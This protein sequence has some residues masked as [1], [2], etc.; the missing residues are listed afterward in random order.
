[1][2]SA[3]VWNEIF[4]PRL[5]ST[6]NDSQL[7]AV[8]S[9]LRSVHCD[10]KA[11][12]KLIWGAPGT[13]KTK[14]VSML[15][16]TLLRMKC[17][18][19]I[20][21]P[22]NIAIREVAS[23]VVKLVKESVERDSG[24]DTLFFPLGEILLFG[25]NE[26]LKVDAGVEEIFLDYRTKGL[27]ECFAPLTGWRN[28]FAS[29]IDFLEE[30]VSQYHIF[31]ENELIKQS[32]DMNDKKIKAKEGIK[33][34]EG[35][36]WA[37]KS[38]LEYLRK[39]FKSIAAPLR[40]CIFNFC[41]HIPRCYIKENNFQAMVA[42]ISLLDS[43][44]TLLFQGN[45]VS[46]DL[47]ELFSH[48]VDRDFSQ[49]IVDIKYLLL[50]G[51]SECYSV[52]RSLWSSFNELDLP[53]AMNKELLKNFCFTNATLIFC[54][55]SSSYKLHSVAMERL[56]FLVIDEA[57]QLKESESTIPLQLPGIKHAILI[58]DEWQLPAMVESNVG[59]CYFDI[60]HKL[61]LVSF[62]FYPLAI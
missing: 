32:E 7:E 46:E 12:V 6:L 21:A 37:I 52:L 57:V 19:L 53:S 24:R 26:R 10:H 15:L 42:L 11:T 16:V 31:L 3:S 4:G 13:G 5:S 18:T 39:R 59:Y 47:E 44:E 1:M 33:D 38:F 22:T 60:L 61:S 56:R 62:A 48:S 51:R 29:M 55:A 50:K 35:S 23:R 30:C 14:T 20:C 9:C 34:T 28:C 58:G 49:S 36:E 17:R 2:Q 41:T 25:N 40:S 27:A 8:F 54:T 45:L 43:F